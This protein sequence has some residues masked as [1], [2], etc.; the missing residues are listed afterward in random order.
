MMQE[1]ILD[2]IDDTHII[3]TVDIVYADLRFG[4]FGFSGALLVEKQFT[5]TFYVKED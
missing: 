1:T 2:V 3:S 4:G 5:I